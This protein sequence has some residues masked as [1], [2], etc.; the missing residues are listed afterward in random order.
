MIL[1]HHVALKNADFSELG[2][3][4]ICPNCNHSVIVVDPTAL[5][6]ST[7]NIRYELEI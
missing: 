5:L 6:H 2:Q 3:A 7:L 4:Y 1:T